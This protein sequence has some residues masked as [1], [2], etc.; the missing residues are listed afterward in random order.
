MLFILKNVD[1]KNHKQGKDKQ[2]DVI[3]RGKMPISNGLWKS[4]TDF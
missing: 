1:L 2:R 3:V 4:I